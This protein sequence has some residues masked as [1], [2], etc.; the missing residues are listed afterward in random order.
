M[1]KIAEGPN[2]TRLRIESEGAAFALKQK[3][4]RVKAVI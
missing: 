2:K 3:S 1:S 4:G